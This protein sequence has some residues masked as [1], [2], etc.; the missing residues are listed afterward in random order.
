MPGS[1]DR[2]PHLHLAIRLSKATLAWTAASGISAIAAAIA[3]GGLSLAG[4]GLDAVAE[5]AASAIVLH[6]F[7]TERRDPQRAHSLERRAARLVAVALGSTGVLLGASAV[8]AL[9]THHSPDASPGR[10]RNRRRIDD[11]AAAAG[12]REE[13]GGRTAWER[14]P[15]GRTAP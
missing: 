5:G 6:R 9:A 7:H 4:Y 12:A 15:A 14:R 2:R 11:R 3:V 13:T 10:D 1:L 8:H